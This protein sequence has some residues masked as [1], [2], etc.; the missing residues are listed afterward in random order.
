[1][2]PIRLL[3]LAAVSAMFA[4]AVPVTA[5]NGDSSAIQARLAINQGVAAFRNAD[6]SRAV[7]FFKQAVELDP[8]ST[9]AQVY[10]ATAYAQQY[11]PGKQSQENLQY[12]S[13]AIESFKRILKKD[14]QNMN[15]LSGL[16]SI[17]Q[18]TGDLANARESFLAVSKID[19]TN[20]VSFYAVGA[21]D[22]L[23]VYDRQ[24]PQ[25]LALQ[26]RL[27]E[28]GLENLDFA[29]SLH[30]DYDDAMIYKNLLIREKVRFTTDPAEQA[31]LTAMAD[32][33]F[34]KALET[35]KRNAQRRT[36]QGVPTG[37]STITVPA[38]PA[39]PVP[40]PSR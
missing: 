36:V 37:S 16:A 12:G 14:P 27:I 33:W 13:N 8:D 23:I 22:W 9:T 1:M 3:I 29:L 17:Y 5:Q 25:P 26:S 34:N 18:N 15:A 24:N 38:L 20:P 40:P 6:Y 4:L 10:L 39:L 21:L 31:K 7:E 2:N 19:S 35:R 28:E 11:V 30:P 32:D